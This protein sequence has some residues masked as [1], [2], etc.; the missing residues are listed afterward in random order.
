MEE[1]IKA[2]FLQVDVL[3][4]HVMEGHYDIVGPGGEIILPQ[5][6]GRLVQPGWSVTMMMWPMDKLPP[7]L[8]PRDFRTAGQTHMPSGAPPP[9]QSFWP[10]GQPPPTYGAPQPQGSRARGQ[11]RMQPGPRMPPGPPIRPMPPVPG[12]H[13]GAH[14]GP[15][16]IINIG[17]PKTPHSKKKKQDSS[18]IGFFA[19]KPPKKKSGKGRPLP[20]SPTSGT[21]TTVGSRVSSTVGRA[22]RP[23]PKFGGGPFQSQ[24][25][26]PAPAEDDRRSRSEHSDTTSE[27]SGPQR[28]AR[29]DAREQGLIIVSRSETQGHRV[30]RHPTF[31]IL[32]K[33]PLPIDRQA[34]S[35]ARLY[36]DEVSE[37]TVCLEL[38]KSGSGI[39]SNFAS[40]DTEHMRWLY[41]YPE[42]PNPPRHIYNLYSLVML[43]AMYWT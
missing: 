14:P 25:R 9:Q 7:P 18:W 20:D 37:G 43:P 24:R 3:G 33:N 31:P 15:P 10:G 6:W 39:T 1:L 30:I 22:P 12:W 23:Q 2:A 11:T 8:G 41:V 5:I 38:T 35:A 40:N 34:F 21:A 13:G 27:S 17:P 19:G 26:A 28:K 29:V 16:N 32:E 4:P 42:F 36:Q